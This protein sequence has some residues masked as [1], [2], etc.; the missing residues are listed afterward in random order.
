MKGEDSVVLEE[1]ILKRKLSVNTHA[2]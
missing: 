2:T 1:I